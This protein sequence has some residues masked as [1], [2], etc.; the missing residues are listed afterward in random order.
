MS[1]QKPCPDSCNVLLIG[2]GGREHALATKLKQSPKLGRLWLTHPENAGLNGLGEACPEPIDLLQP[3][4][5]QRWC[6]RNVLHLVLVGPEAPLA[7]GI[8]DKLKANGRLVFGPTSAGAQ[9]EADKAFSRDLMRQ[10]A[11]PNAEA[12]VFTRVEDAERW[13]EARDELVAYLES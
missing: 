1:R 10:A 7:D 9:S 11:V 4:H 6:D 12:Q 8:A 2:G 13:I 5:L 3:F